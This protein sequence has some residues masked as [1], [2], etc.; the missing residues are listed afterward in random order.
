MLFYLM[1]CVD[2]LTSSIAI[3]IGGIGELAPSRRSELALFGVKAMLGGTFAAFM[4]AS[5]VGLLL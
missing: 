3:Q 1:L 5:I 4:T 2:L